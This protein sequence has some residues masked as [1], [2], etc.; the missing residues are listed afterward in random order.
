MPLGPYKGRN[1]TL[2]VEF[3]P[4]SQHCTGKTREGGRSHP[5]AAEGIFCMNPAM[6]WNPKY[7]KTTMHTWAM[8]KQVTGWLKFVA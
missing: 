6:L 5:P 1:R 4:I 8:L 3:I 2:W 7:S